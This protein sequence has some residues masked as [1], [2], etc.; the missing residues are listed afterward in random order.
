MVYGFMREMWVF[1]VVDEVFWCVKL[2]RGWQCVVVD[3]PDRI[4]ATC[5]DLPNCSMRC[6]PLSGAHSDAVAC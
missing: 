2:P 6:Q 5:L 1:V 3:T 4:C